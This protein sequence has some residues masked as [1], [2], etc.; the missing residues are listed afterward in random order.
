MN[1]KLIIILVIYSFDSISGGGIDVEKKIRKLRGDLGEDGDCDD[2]EE[3][4]IVRIQWEGNGNFGKRFT[5]SS[6]ISSAESGVPLPILEPPFHYYSSS[7]NDFEREGPNSE[8]GGLQ[9]NVRGGN[10]SESSGKLKIYEI[11]TGVSLSGDESSGFRGKKE[12]DLRRSRDGDEDKRK[13]GEKQNKNFGKWESDTSFRNFVERKNFGKVENEDNI[14]RWKS[15]GNSGKGE[16]EDNFGKWRSDGNFGKTE[17][18]DSFRKWKS[19]GHFGKVENEDNFGKWKSDEK[20]GKDEDFVKLKNYGKENNNSNFDRWEN[21]ENFK[22]GDT[23][24]N[25][26]KLGDDDIRKT[27]ISASIGKVENSSDFGK[28][29]SKNVEY[30]GNNKNFG[31]LNSEITGKFYD[32]ENRGKYEGHNNFGNKENIG[33][34]DSNE[35]LRNDKKIENEGKTEENFFRN[36]QNENYFGKWENDN[37]FDR[38]GNFGSFGDDGNLRKFEKSPN[39]KVLRIDEN[40]KKFPN[41]DD[42][43]PFQNFRNFGTGPSLKVLK[44]DENSRNFQSNEDFK[45]FQNN[46]HFGNGQNLKVLKIGENFERFPATENVRKFENSDTLKVLKI[47]ENRENFHST[48][49]FHDDLK[50][51]SGNLEN[52]HNFEKSKITYQNIN[53]GWFNSKTRNNNFDIDDFKKINESDGK[54]K[55]FLN[56]Q[57]NENFNNFDH[58]Q[59][60]ENRNKNENESDEN[61]ENEQIKLNIWDPSKS[62]VKSRPTQSPSVIQANQL[63]AYPSRGNRKYQ[64]HTSES[65]EITSERRNSWGFSREKYLRK[66][67]AH[68]NGVNHF[69]YIDSNKFGAIPGVPGRDYPINTENRPSSSKKFTCPIR[70]KTH[71][72]IADRSS[73]CQV[74]Y[75][76]YANNPAVQMVCPDGTLFNQQLQVCDWWF[77]VTC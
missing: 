52:I 9:V 57:N 24:N 72:Y 67:I 30:N 61:N 17:N 40:P 25:F 18:E 65:D 69:R 48:G 11:T 16:N 13:F 21:Y 23:K 76:C 68:S 51:N 5:V 58:D 64:H 19:D 47:D 35:R 22:I 36:F 14:S 63:K 6:E 37:K 60:H 75:V 74:F 38:N 73:R 31:K 54:W 10:Y 29:E 4:S 66:K 71:I 7:I 44:I 41:N 62:A 3:E 42:Y 2:E 8:R 15:D 53:D 27:D 55:N 39:L 12:E 46:K 34:W 28:W 33:K 56:V 45:Q 26:G 20:F 32:S 43:K 50:I 1:I 77:N 70:T 49:K 59:K